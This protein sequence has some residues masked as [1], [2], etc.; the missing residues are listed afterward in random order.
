LTNTQ[1]KTVAA[2]RVFRASTIEE[3]EPFAEAWDRLAAGAPFQSWAW[4]STWWRHY[5]DGR[6]D[7]RRLCAACVFD[8][9]DVL[10][11]VAPWYVCPS[12]VWG[13][14]LRFLGTDDVCSDYLSVLCQRGFED[15]VA[16]ALA[17]WLL[18][19]RASEEANAGGRRE[20]WGL[21]ELLGVDA[22]DRIVP[23]LADRLGDGGSAVHRR[24]GAS[25]WRVSLPPTVDE[26]VA[27]FSKNSR[28][29]FRRARREMLD[30]GRAVLHTAGNTTEL[31]E[32]LD[33]LIDL[34]Q[35][36]RRALG[37]PGCFASERFAA[38]HR[39]VAR[40]MF[41]A[42]QAQVHV[43]RCEGRPIAA[44]YQLCGNGVVYA[45]QTGIDPE[46]LDMEP[47]RICQTAVLCW[48]IDN[49]YRAYDMLRG[50]EPYKLHWQAQP[51]LGIETRIASSRPAARFRH[52]V[53]RAGADAKQWIKK[54][55][56]QS[57]S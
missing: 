51:A 6:S 45:Y 10:V 2:M 26:Y 46:R 1:N 44:E 36:R 12:R 49:G 14:V 37:Q 33:T 20:R 38:F 40:R 5:G 50:D 25:C 57:R 3:L 8:R 39:E 56:K 43:L 16:G 29:R 35:R 53:W 34:H 47:G 30:S 52:T 24:E 9:R 55:L 41:L 11:G 13:G 32:G 22:R 18:G 4:M 17:D 48:A 54:G 23:C 21:I 42:G 27:G 15:D 28:K 31:A 7:G 19:R